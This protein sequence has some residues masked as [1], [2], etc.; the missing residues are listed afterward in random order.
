MNFQNIVLRKRLIRHQHCGIFIR[1]EYGTLYFGESLSNGWK[2]TLAEAKFAHRKKEDLLVKR[3]PVD[4]YVI[5]N[6]IITWKSY[7]NYQ[8]LLFQ[9]IRQLSFNMIDLEA[10]KKGTKF[11]YC[12]QSC[13]YWIYRLTDKKICQYWFS[14]DTQ[15][16]QFDRNGIIV[17]L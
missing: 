10:Q 6:E 14:T 13:A 8:G 11:T 16:L 2:I 4:T 17:E 12:S 5:P 1:D 3:F 7:Y 9:L 15:D